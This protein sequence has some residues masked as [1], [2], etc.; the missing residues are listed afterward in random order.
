MR[1]PIKM[2][3][4]YQCRLCQDYYWF[5]FD[6]EEEQVAGRNG[7]KVTREEAIILRLRI[8]MTKAGDCTC[9]RCW[10]LEKKRYEARY[11]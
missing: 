7:R 4:L 3:Y 8:P 6:E 5:H 11:L 2:D 10:E 9:P 1:A